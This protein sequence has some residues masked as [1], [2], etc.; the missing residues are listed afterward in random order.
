MARTLN[1]GRR[2]SSST[3]R[4]P[5]RNYSTNLASGGSV[6]VRDGVKTFSDNKLQVRGNNDISISGQSYSRNKGGTGFSPVIPSDKV[7]PLPELKLPSATAPTAVPDADVTNASLA[8]FGTVIEGNKFVPDPTVSDRSNAVAEANLAGRQGLAEYINS[9]RPKEGQNENALLAARKQSGFG[10]AQKEVNRYQNQINVITGKRDAQMLGLEDQGRGI[11][12]TIIGGQQ[13]RISREA[14]IM[15]MPLQ[16]Q[17]AAAQGNLEVAATLMGQLFTAK[18]ADIAAGAQFRQSVGAAL[19]NYSN[20]SQANLL[21]AKMADI[22]DKAAKEQA[23]LVFLRQNVDSAI[24]SGA[25][26]AEVG[27]LAS[28][29]LTAAQKVA[30]AQSITARGVGEMRSLDIQAQRAN[31]AQSQAATSASNRAN[32]PSAVTRQTEMYE[33]KLIDSQTG[34]VIKDLSGGAPVL[35]ATTKRQVGEQLKAGENLLGLVTQYRGLIKTKGFE[36]TAYGSQD[37]VGKYNALRGQITASYKDAK[38]L[39]TLDAGLLTLVDSIIGESPTSGAFT[40]LRNFFGGASNRVVS[41]LD[42]LIASTE[43]ENEQARAQLGQYNTEV[44]NIDES[45]YIDSFLGNPVN[46]TA[47]FTPVSNYFR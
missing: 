38:K 29:S 4:T 37:T 44:I 36:S 10:D 34:E 14:A 9:I 46:Q 47:T 32:R 2:S 17:L 7:S 15:A 8:G 18:S 3:G 21:N 45:N 5:N 30:L 27:N 11:S 39:G 25:T 33:G 23:D 41:Q 19:L 43:K 26:A 35:D 12:E 1:R 13:A 16:A 6:S 20:T 24:K 31:I 42:S 22:A 28:D 40:P